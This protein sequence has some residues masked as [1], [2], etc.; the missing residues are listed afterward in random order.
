MVNLF[1]HLRC[2]RINKYRLRGFINISLTPYNDRPVHPE[3]VDFQQKATPAVNLDEILTPLNHQGCLIHVT[4]FKGQSLNIRP[5]PHLPIILRRLS[6]HKMETCEW[7]MAKKTKNVFAVKGEKIVW[8]M[9]GISLP[10]G[11]ATITSCF[12]SPHVDIGDIFTRL[13]SVCAKLNYWSFMRNTKPWKCEAYL[14]LFPPSSS[15]LYNKN[16]TYTS[17][18]YVGAWYYGT[19]YNPW[20]FPGSIAKLNVL[21]VAQRMHQIF[22][23]NFHYRDW[24]HQHLVFHRF[25]WDDFWHSKVN[26]MDVVT[27]VFL[28]IEMNQVSKSFEASKD[29]FTFWKLRICLNCYGKTALHMSLFQNLGHDSLNYSLLSN[30]IIESKMETRWKVYFNGDDSYGFTEPN[31]FLFYFDKC[32][33][34]NDYPLLKEKPVLFQT[35]AIV[36]MWRIIMNNFTHQRN[37]KLRGADPNQEECTSGSDSFRKSTVKSP[38]SMIQLNIIQK[39]AM[40]IPEFYPMTFPNDMVTLRLVSCGRG[41]LGGLAYSELLSVFQWRVWVAFALSVIASILLTIVIDNKCDMCFN[42]L[43]LTIL[44]HLKIFVEQSSALM[45][46]SLSDKWRFFVGLYVLVGIVLSNAYKNT[47]VYRMVQ[48]RD[49]TPYETFAQLVHDNFIIFARNVAFVSFAGFSEG[50]PLS[51]QQNEY[52]R[53]IIHGNIGNYSFNMGN[54][55]SE[56]VKILKLRFRE[57]ATTPNRLRLITFKNYSQLHPDLLKIYNETGHEFLNRKEI[58]SSDSKEVKHI[59]AERFKEKEQLALEKS[60]KVCNRV[61]LLLPEHLTNKVARKMRNVDNVYVGKEAL[62]KF[63]IG[64]RLSG[65]VPRQVLFRIKVVWWAGLWDKWE[66]LLWS[67]TGRHTQKHNERTQLTKSNMSGNILIL[68]ALL[69]CGFAFSILIFALECSKLIF[70]VILKLGI[71]IMKYYCRIHETL[72]LNYKRGIAKV[73]VSLPKMPEVGSKQ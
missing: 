63:T 48:P 26:L 18:S 71:K 61:A 47:N 49:P 6:L 35:S 32:G 64:V 23:T 68:F 19:E 12:N 70:S 25:S 51:L 22:L 52:E 10:T 3:E 36:H 28:I 33:N 59:W 69:L 66:K 55:V 62:Q 11:N 24:V 57:N 73:K 34:Q 56:I 29:M 46:T 44:R 41:Q 58:A 42:Y 2:Q 9:Q 39:L 45:T 14:R 4:S 72:N 1:Q 7:R 38:F 20:I 60:L 65:Y 5:S 16:S 21:L 30:P 43:T 17:I 37:V 53:F 27:D 67:K 8:V 50:M 40:D 31:T 15:L 54:F 13:S